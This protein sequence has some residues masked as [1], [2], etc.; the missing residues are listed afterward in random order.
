MF[1]LSQVTSPLSSNLG[2]ST[3][4]GMAACTTETGELCY[5]W[6]SGEVYLGVGE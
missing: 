2:Y 1:V 3:W 5:S 4:F 6:E